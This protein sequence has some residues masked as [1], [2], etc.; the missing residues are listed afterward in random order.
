MTGQ[1]WIL[2]DASRI[3]CDSA[4]LVLNGFI[5]GLEWTKPSLFILLPPSVSLSDP[6]LTVETVTVVMREL[7][8]WERVARGRSPFTFCFRI[9]RSKLRE[10]KQ[11]ASSERDNSYALGGYWVNTDPNASWKK[12]AHIL[13]EEEVQRAALRV[14][15][16]LPEGMNP[17]NYMNLGLCSVVF[18]YGCTLILTDLL[19]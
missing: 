3:P 9:P 19:A 2:S 8:H 15:Q 6:N 16:Y 7:E 4:D 5:D 18:T 13:Y 12:L 10:I 11:Q 14:K 1:D 17:F